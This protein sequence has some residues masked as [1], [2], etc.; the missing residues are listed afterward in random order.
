VV[1]NSGG[2]FSSPSALASGFDQNTQNVLIIFNTDADVVLNF[3]MNNLNLSILAPRSKLTVTVDQRDIR[4]FL[5]GRELV[6]T[7][8]NISHASATRNA[9]VPI[10]SCHHP[11]S[12]YY[13]RSTS[14][15]STCHWWKRY[16]RM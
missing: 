6:V 12:C 7:G 14:Y 4:G 5:I 8:G 16:L 15:P 2:T 13:V 9:V 11:S 1:I 10:W 3:G